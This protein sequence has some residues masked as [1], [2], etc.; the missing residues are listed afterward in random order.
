MLLFRVFHTLNAKQGDLLFD[1]E[2]QRNLL[3]SAR[4]TAHGRLFET[5][6]YLLKLLL[7]WALIQDVRFFKHLRYIIVE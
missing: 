4:L 2:R 6:A 1:T 5:C 3:K 7:G